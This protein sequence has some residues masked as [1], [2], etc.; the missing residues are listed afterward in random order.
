MK[1]KF[2]IFIVCV[3][4][5]NTCLSPVALASSSNSDLGS[6]DVSVDA[7]GKVT[8]GP[9][10]AATHTSGATR[11]SIIHIIRNYKEIAAVVLGICVIT[12]IIMLLIAI[13]RLGA[14]GDNQQARANSWK[15]I[16][17]SGVALSLFGGAGAAIGIFW[18]FLK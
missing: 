14:S 4:I 11:Y 5:M 9:S 2:L 17:V 18:N 6:V 16:I 3:M 7:N 12:S 10:G 8:V 15:A 13:L 1:K